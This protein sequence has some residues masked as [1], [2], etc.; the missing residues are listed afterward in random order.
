MVRLDVTLTGDCMVR[1]SLLMWWTIPEMQSGPAK[2]S[3]SA[4]KRK[5]MLRIR[6]LPKAFRKARQIHLGPWGWMP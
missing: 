5:M 1:F 3:R 2:P 4:M 6:G